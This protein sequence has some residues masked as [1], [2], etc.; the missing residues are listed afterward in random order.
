LKKGVDINKSDNHG[1]T[2][3][4][5]SCENGY[6]EIVKLLIEN[7]VDINKFDNDGWTS[8]HTSCENGHLEIVKLLIKKRC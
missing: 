3:L 7:G 2:P 6:L 5:I 8:L 1:W 4:H